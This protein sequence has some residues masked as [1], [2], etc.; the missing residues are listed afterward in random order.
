MMF[1]SHDCNPREIVHPFN[2]VKKNVY[3]SSSGCVSL[4][5]FQCG[6]MIVAIQLYN[7]VSVS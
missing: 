2:I 5:F 4:D 7:L 1:A 6:L 3:W